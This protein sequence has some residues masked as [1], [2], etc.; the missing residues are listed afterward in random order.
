MALDFVE[1]SIGVSWI[2]PLLERLLTPQI[3]RA[4]EKWALA[5]VGLSALAA[6]GFASL[7]YGFGVAGERLTRRLREIAFK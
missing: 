5:F 3:E 6:I 4:G 2:K 7:S 1:R